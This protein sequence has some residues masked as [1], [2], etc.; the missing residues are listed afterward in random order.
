MTG[1]MRR[2]F[3]MGVYP[4]RRRGGKTD[5]NRLT[6]RD[7]TDPLRD[8]C[9]CF[10]SDS[11]LRLHLICQEN[12]N[13][14]LEAPSVPVVIQNQRHHGAGWSGHDDG[15]L[16][17]ELLGEV[18][19][20]T[21]VIHVEVRDQHGTNIID[22]HSFGELCEIGKR[23]PR[24]LPDEGAAVQ[25]HML[26]ADREKEATLANTLPSSEDGEVD[27]SSTHRSRNRAQESTAFG[28]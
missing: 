19:K 8:V 20:P 1:D 13:C 26:V 22:L 15:P 18:Q 4:S 3:G 27:G 11:V 28:E 16:V 12:S 9:K 23:L 17:L 24:I 14:Q 10:R 7:V 21:D 5:L 25:E 6:N 2:H